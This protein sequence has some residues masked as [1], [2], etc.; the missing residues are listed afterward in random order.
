ME[1]YRAAADAYIF[2]S[3][4]ASEVSD[5]VSGQL[6]AVLDALPRLVAQG[7]GSP[8]ATA[9]LVPGSWSGPGWSGSA[10]A[11]PFRSW[12]RRPRRRSRKCTQE[13]G[14]TAIDPN[15]RTRTSWLVREP[16]VKLGRRSADRARGGGHWGAE[17]DAMYEIFGRLSAGRASAALVVNGGAI[18]L[19][20]VERNLTQGRPIVVVAGSGRAADAI[21][22]HVRGTEPTEPVARELR[23]A[24]SWLGLDAHRE[25]VHVIDLRA[26]ARARALGLQLLLGL[27][28]PR[29][30]AAQL[31]SWVR[32]A[33]TRAGTCGDRCAT[34][35]GAGRPPAAPIGC[36]R[37]TEAGS[38]G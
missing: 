13:P 29:P 27:P 37:S 4:G 16:G 21:V 24:V 6:R 30:D 5:A 36:W 26:G 35:T 18:T 19:D 28:P 8:W 2:L 9:A 11:A 22:A 32:R 14:R 23:D 1:K 38:A 15:R 20:E 17:T 3:G 25:S 12:A 7:V 34:A 31:D 10:R 33:R